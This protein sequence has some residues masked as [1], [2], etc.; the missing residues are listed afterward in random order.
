MDIK[1]ILGQV[2]TCFRHN[3]VEIVIIFKGL[4]FV[5]GQSISQNVCSRLRGLNEHY[6]LAFKVTF[7][8]APEKKLWPIENAKS[9]TLQVC[10]GV[11]CARIPKIFY[12][13][14]R[15]IRTFLKIPLKICF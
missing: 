10:C 1:N 15:D 2:K 13:A 7:Q 6:K 5:N 14:V 4:Y 11:Y 12:F 3:K 9:Q 8:V